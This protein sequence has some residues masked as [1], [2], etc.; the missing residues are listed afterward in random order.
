VALGLAPADV[1][2][3]DD[4]S[5]EVPIHGICRNG[6]NALEAAGLVLKWQKSP[7]R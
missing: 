3:H 5:I 4:G 6:Q 1:I 7:M 2:Q